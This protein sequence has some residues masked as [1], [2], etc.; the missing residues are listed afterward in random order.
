MHFSNRALAAGTAARVPFESVLLQKSAAALRYRVE[1][2]TARRRGAKEVPCCHGCTNA[3][4]VLLHVCPGSVEH[5][6]TAYV[7]MTPD[8]Y[9]SGHRCG[10]GTC[11]CKC[12][13]YVEDDAGTGLGGGGVGE[14]P[15]VSAAATGL[16]EGGVEEAVVTAVK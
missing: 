3:E 8:C 14:V 11:R 13:F 15:I 6:C 16:K 4:G 5:G 12:R 9:N 1:M 7:C 2:A 10:K